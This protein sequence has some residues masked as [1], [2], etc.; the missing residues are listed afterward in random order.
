MISW[1]SLFYRRIKFLE[2][3]QLASGIFKEQHR[4]SYL[5]PEL[6]ES[7]ENS[8]SLWAA[9]LWGKVPVL[10]AGCL[11]PVQS[12]EAA[13]WCL[14]QQFGFSAQLSPTKHCTPHGAVCGSSPALSLLCSWHTQFVCPPEAHFSCSTCFAT[15]HV[16]CSISSVLLCFFSLF[17]PGVYILKNAE[18][19]SS[20]LEQKCPRHSL[21]LT[22][23]FSFKGIVWINERLFIAGTK[24]SDMPEMSKCYYA[25]LKGPLFR[26][27]NGNFMPLQWNHKYHFKP[28]P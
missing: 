24:C 4:G 16:C 19:G 18:E 23:S 13:P 21:S 11:Q 6:K 10:G 9:R 5:L 20:T 27:R 28:C 22:S 12:W 8:I 17:S 2:K 14:E 25:P 1:F 7:C 15:V 3:Y 26:D